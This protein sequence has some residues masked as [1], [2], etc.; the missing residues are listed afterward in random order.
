M[1]VQEA[2][3]SDTRVPVPAPGTVLQITRYGKVQAIVINPEDFAVIEAMLD[4][5]RAH[6]PVEAELSDLE[7]RAHDATDAPETIDDYDYEGLAA[8]VVR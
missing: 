8:A 6:P 5:Y 1:L 7:L 2:T 3:A 4:A